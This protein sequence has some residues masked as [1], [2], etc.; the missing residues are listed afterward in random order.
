[1]RREEKELEAA[2]IK[3]RAR[4]KALEKLCEE[5]KQA[6]EDLTKARDIG[7]RRGE[8]CAVCKHSYTIRDYSLNWNH[9]IC[10]YGENPGHFERAFIDELLP[11][12]ERKE[13]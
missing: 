10:L 6:I 5:Q 3:E 2:L 12:V 4:A 13:L 7:C 8:W 9:C 11:I 1:M